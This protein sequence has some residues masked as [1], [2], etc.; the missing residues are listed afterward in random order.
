M[1][2]DILMISSLAGLSV[3]LA[4]SCSVRVFFLLLPG[5]L[6]RCRSV[7]VAGSLLGLR[8]PMS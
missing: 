8:V 4:L 3:S 2:L 6:G 7:V 1:K 5:L